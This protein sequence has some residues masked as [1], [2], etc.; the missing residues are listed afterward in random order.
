DGELTISASTTDNNGNAV[1]ADTGVDLDTTAPAI[2][3]V[4]VSQQDTD[5]PADGVAD[6]TVVTFAADDATAIYAVTSGGETATITDNGNGTYTATFSPAL[7]AGAEITV[8][9]TDVVGNTDSVTGTVPAELTYTDTTPPTVEVTSSIAS[10]SAGDNAEITFTFSELPVG[11]AIEDVSVTGGA[12][13][14]FTQVNATTWTAVF[15]AD[16]TQ[17]ISITV[18]GAGYQDLA[19][20][21]GATV[22]QSINSNP[23]VND[24]VFNPLEDEPLVGNVLNESGATDLDGNTLSIST[25]TVDGETYN[26]GQIVEI[27]G[28]GTFTLAANGDGNFTPVEHWSGDVPEITYTVTD[29]N[30]GSTTAGLTINVVAVA[31]APTLSVDTPAV[32]DITGLA[33]LSTQTWTNQSLE[34]NGNGIE[35][36][37]LVAN[38]NAITAESTNTVTTNVSVDT[39]T[40]LAAETAVKMSGLIYLEAGQT[41]NFGGFADDSV[42]ITINGNIVA[43]GRWGDGTSGNF[44]G[45]FTASQSGYYQLDVYLHNAEG[46]G[47]YNLVVGTD[48]GVLPLSTDNFDIFQDTSTLDAAGIRYGESLDGQV[49]IFF[50]DNEGDAATAIPISQINAAL[51]DTD[52]SETLSVSIAG[53]PVGSVIS[54]GVNSYTVPAGGV[55]DVTGWNLSALTLTTPERVA[56]QIDLTVTVTATE[57]SNG[58][59]AS[60]TDVISV[61]VNEVN[62]APDA[63]DD[64]LFATE[65]TTAI[66]TVAEL[67]ANDSDWNG[68]ALSITGVASGTG[69]T[70]TLNE[71]GTITFVPDSNFSGDASFTYQVTDTGGR[72]STATVTVQV[73]PVA[74]MPTLETVDVVR[75]AGS[76]GAAITTATNLS[77]AAIESALGLPA[78]YLDTFDAPSGAVNH[79]GNVNVTNGEYTSANINLASG[80]TVSYNWAFTNGEDVNSQIANGFNDLLL[81]I[82]T[83]PDGT[84]TAQVVSSSEFLGAGN[85]GTGTYNLTATQ[86]GDYRID[87]LVLNGGDTAKNSSLT[88]SVPNITVDGSAYR[89]TGLTINAAVTD[90]SETLTITVHDVPV[91]SRLSAGILNAD[92]TWTLTPAELS[93]LQLLTPTTFRGAISLRIE[94]TSVDGDS[95]ISNY[96]MLDVIIADNQINGNDLNNTFTLNGTSDSDLIYGLGGNDRLNGTT[97]SG[98]NDILFGGD[99]RDTLNGGDGDDF[100]SGGAGND[101]LNGGNGNDYLWSG[102]GNDTMTGGAGADTFAWRLSDQGTASTPARDVITDFNQAQGDV[103][104]LRDLLQGEESATDLSQYLSFRA[105]GSST[106]IDVSHEGNGVI[107]QRIE[108]QNVTLTAPDLTDQEIIQALINSG[109][110]RIDQ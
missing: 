7:A 12:L 5:K 75:L 58:S 79:N 30:G 50:G 10:M 24:L 82:V 101:T 69:G 105:Q 35:G 20:N 83:A 33:G 77:Q 87:W 48:S 54:D 32:V 109:N 25:F 38:M 65:D 93:G 64:L 63:V 4:V 19:G 100:L 1:E 102:A 37:V 6:Q 29:G 31:D 68:D 57:I 73:A 28:I 53:I 92:G 46:A 14:G 22:T 94:A 15:T 99:G 72:T 86:T 39:S 81:L 45:N 3:D 103:L 55:A 67:L 51:V 90:P 52:G 98:G 17:A 61:S 85:S 106:I 70:V 49:I 23:I 2:T 66:F 43:E 21:Q 62:V 89:A 47:G 9:G 27:D 8:T 11:F 97:G 41:Y 60:T 95:S 56:G 104:D 40:G 42:A 16:G 76:S 13:S 71:N 91:G 78:G 18:D 36:S 110:L 107:T 74:D 96:A 59:T 88:L 108:L 84:R 80:M 44:G 34:S 26:A